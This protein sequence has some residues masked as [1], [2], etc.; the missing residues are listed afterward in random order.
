MQRFDLVIPSPSRAGQ[1]MQD[2][3]SPTSRFMAFVADG[4][5]ADPDAGQHAV[6]AAV[7]ERRSGAALVRSSAVLATMLS[8]GFLSA[9]LQTH[10][11][12]LAAA[13]V[14]EAPAAA[15][16]APDE[17]ETARPPMYQGEPGVY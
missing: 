2:A 8:I 6:L 15:L 1:T 11:A 17:T 9:L 7:Q 5:P 10:E 12:P 16:V 4:L 14:T 3:P 13:A